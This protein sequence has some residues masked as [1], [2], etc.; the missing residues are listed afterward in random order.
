MQNDKLYKEYTQLTRKDIRERM[1]L[2]FLTFPAALFVVGNVIWLS[3]QSLPTTL[4]NRKLRNPMYKPYKAAL[5]DA[6]IP[7]DKYTV[8]EN[9]YKTGQLTVNPNP[10]F[11]L[12][13]MWLA[14]L[15]ITLL[16]Y[17][18]TTCSAV[19]HKSDLDAIDMMVDLEK[20]GKHYNLNRK[21]VKKLIFLSKEIIAKMSADKRVYFDMLTN[22]DINIANNKTFVDMA[23]A[24]LDGHL[25]TH[26][27]DTAD[28]FKIF[29]ENKQ[30]VSKLNTAIRAR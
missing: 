10:K 29:A 25:R 26:E 28:V 18:G 17:L 19:L 23:V 8:D 5:H 27:Q 22:G 1:R 6:Y 9:T 21:Q 30:I 2:E 4:F 14:N 13:G 24:I 12:N 7:T 20:F 3:M 11:K 15:L 16:L